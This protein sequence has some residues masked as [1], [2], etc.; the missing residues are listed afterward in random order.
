MNKE[1]FTLGD[2]FEDSLND[3]FDNVENSEENL[4]ATFTHAVYLCKALYNRLSP[5]G[6]YPALT[7]GTLYKKEPKRKDIDIVIY[8]KRQNPQFEMKDLEEHLI[9]LGFCDFQ[10]YGFVTKCKWLDI[11][12]DLFN[13]ETQSTFKSDNYDGK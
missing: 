4:N 11:N 13:P 2:I 1:T 10:Y 9:D 7:G 6:F 3:I 12:V 8:R 5:I